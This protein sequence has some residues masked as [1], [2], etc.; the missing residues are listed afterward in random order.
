MDTNPYQP[1]QSEIITQDSSGALAS[2]WIR[3]GAIIIDGLV[4]F[5]INFIIQKVFLKMPGPAEIYDAVRAGKS[6][7]SLMPGTGMVILVNLLGLGVFLAVNFVFLKKGQTIGKLALK[8][9]IQRRSDG[10]L[11]PVQDIILRRLLPVWGVSMLGNALG[12]IFATIAGIFILVDALCIFRQQRN[13]IHDDIAG[14]KVVS[15]KK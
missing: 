15:L 2:P 14:T 6:M 12:T 5:P 10:S 1:P 3:L 8:L 9:Q 7:E 4:L 13:T 11:L